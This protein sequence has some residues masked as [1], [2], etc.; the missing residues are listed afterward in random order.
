MHELIAWEFNEYPD[1]ESA[2]V[3]GERISCKLLMKP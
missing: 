2:A 3:R 1:G